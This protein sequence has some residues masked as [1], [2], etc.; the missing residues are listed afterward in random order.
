DFEEYAEE[1]FDESIFVSQ[2]SVNK[3]L[4][5]PKAKKLERD[6][7]FTAM[8]AMMKYNG[9]IGQVY[10]QSQMQLKSARRLFIQALRKM[11]PDKHYYPDAN[12]TMRFTYG[13][14]G[15]YKARD[16]VYYRY[17]TTLEGVMDKK[18]P[19]DL[20]FHVP[21]KL[22]E[23]YK[24]KDYGRYGENGEMVVAFLT[25]NDITGGNSGSPVLNGDGELIGIAFDGNWEAMSGDIAFEPRVQR[26][27]SVDIRYVL[28]VIDKFAGAQ[29]LIDELTIA[30]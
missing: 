10:Q 8:E 3:F 11:N 26:T 12:S 18:D 17:Q 14:V 30:N 16:A 19:T 27:I 1:V 2:E 25:D 7:A 24:A 13:E 6:P 5:K 4:D 29:N 9:E 23:L 21:D 22:E 28:F 20:E 15:G